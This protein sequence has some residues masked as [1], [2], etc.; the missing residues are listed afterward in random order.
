MSSEKKF[1]LIILVVSIAA[2]IA[3]GS[4]AF[5]LQLRI[6]AIDAKKTGAGRELTDAVTNWQEAQR[7]ID[8]AVLHEDIANFGVGSTTARQQVFHTVSKEIGRAWFY[9]QLA[10]TPDQNVLDERMD[11]LCRSD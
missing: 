11:N 9:K 6:G 5:W 4:L 3:T 7:H 1:T 10:I 2:T 8:L